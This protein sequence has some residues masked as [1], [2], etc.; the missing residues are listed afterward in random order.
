MSRPENKKNISGDI[1]EQLHADLI[2]WIEAHKNQKIA[3]CLQTMVEL[4]L[5]LSERVQGLLLL[6]NRD[7]RLFGKAAEEVN[8]GITSINE[9]IQGEVKD[10][11]DCIRRVLLILQDYANTSTG[12]SNIHD[13]RVLL[14]TACDFFR[15]VNLDKMD[16]L[17]NNERE[18]AMNVQKILQEHREFLICGH[19]YRDQISVKKAVRRAGQQSQKA[20]PSKK[21]LHNS[22]ESG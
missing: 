1:P 8:E 2:E 20:K 10:K 21:K 9:I 3:P 16:G 22:G 19:S 15:S 6:T 12:F 18:V 5:A 4:W 17:L 11:S 13:L 14:D 7:S